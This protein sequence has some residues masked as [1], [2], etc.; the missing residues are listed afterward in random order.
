MIE[1]TGDP[2]RFDETDLVSLVETS[3]ASGPALVASIMATL[4]ERAAG[5]PFDDDIPF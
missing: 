1:A 3:G 5:R 4:E 2:A